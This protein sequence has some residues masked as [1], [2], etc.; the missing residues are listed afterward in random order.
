[1]TVTIEADKQDFQ[2]DQNTAHFS[3]NVKVDYGSITIQSPIAVLT[4]N[5][6]GQPDK[7]VFSKGASAIRKSQDASD[8]LTAENIT[9]MIASNQLI[10][11]GNSFA[12]IKQGSEAAVTISADT[13]EFNNVTNEIKASGSVKVTYKG[14]QLFANQAKLTTDKTG[15]PYRAEL[16]GNA[17]VVRH[18]GT[19]SGGTITYDVNSNN[20]SASGGVNTV[21]SLPGSGQVTMRSDY[22]QYDRASNIIIGSGHVRVTYQDYIATGPKATI[23]TAG[24]NNID[25]IVFTGRAQIADSQRK[26]TANTI[27]V[28]LNPKNFIAEGNVKTQFVQ[29][30]VPEAA[31]QPAVKEEKKE[32]KEP[33]KEQIEQK[34]EEKKPY[35]KPEEEKNVNKPEDKNDKA[36]DNLENKENN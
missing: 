7:A 15:K 27:T 11:R 34:E 28:S 23:Y 35:E 4:S 20:I 5:E 14:M 26:V 13:Q 10:A 12:S 24:G 21:T 31:S 8:K 33:E 9:L 32:T 25:K 36:A 6:K 2:V 29:K 17:R 19:I 22:Q 1:M 3:G 30:N 18:N 16:S